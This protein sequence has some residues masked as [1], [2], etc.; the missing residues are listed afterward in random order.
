MYDMIKCATG[1]IAGFTTFGYSI[2]ALVAISDGHGGVEI[3]LNVAI[4]LMT[5]IIVLTSMSVQMRL[6]DRTERRVVDRIVSDQFDLLVAA[7]VTAVDHK[8]KANSKHT[9]ELIKAEVAAA[10]EEISTRAFRAA[11]V[12]QAT[13][14][15]AAGTA[16]AQEASVAYIPSRRR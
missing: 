6:A 5:L 3:P 10:V 4:P 14:A 7:I 16:D 1:W 9:R 2:V 13:Q 12:A 15:A 11:V 8:I